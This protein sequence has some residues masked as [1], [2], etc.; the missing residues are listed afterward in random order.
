MHT[1]VVSLHYIYFEWLYGGRMWATSHGL[2][3]LSGEIGTVYTARKKK[4]SGA[5][6]DARKGFLL[7]DQIPEN[8]II[9]GETFFNL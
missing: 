3:I 2:Y 4:K 7:C 9:D 8:C 5:K 6:S 1:A